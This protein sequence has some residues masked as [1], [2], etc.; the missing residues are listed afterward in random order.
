MIRQIPFKEG[1]EVT[2]LEQGHRFL[3][4]MEDAGLGLASSSSSCN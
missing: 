1:D 2:S 4:G 3:G